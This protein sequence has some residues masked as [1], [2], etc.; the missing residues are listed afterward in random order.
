M[1]Q[2]PIYVPS[3][4][5]FYANSLCNVPWP[6]GAKVVLY[7]TGTNNSNLLIVFAI[8]EMHL[9]LCMD[10]ATTEFNP[11]KRNLHIRGATCHFCQLPPTASEMQCKHLGAIRPVINLWSILP[12]CHCPSK[13]EDQGTIL[14]LKW[15]NHLRK[16]CSEMET[17]WSILG[18][19]PDDHLVAVAFF[20]SPKD[21]Q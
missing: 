18:S 1:G 15:L 10:L 5:I 9:I 2:P 6:H 20:A 17:L 19:P 14:A 16:Q 13:N 8:L 12:R 3:S 7:S 11:R 21:Y 4:W